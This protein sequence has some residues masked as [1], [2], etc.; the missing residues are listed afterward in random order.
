MSKQNVPALRLEGFSGE[1]EDCTL[2]EHSHV[3]TG[4]SDVQDADPDGLYPFFVRSQHVERSNKYLFDGEAI[5]IPGEGRLGE[6]FHYYIGKFDFHQRVYRISDFED[7]D[8]KYV[9]WAMQHSFKDHAMQNTVKATVDSLRQPTITGF[10]FQ[11]P[12]TLEEQ[13]AIGAIFTNLD[14]AINQHMLKHKALQQSKTALMQRM[15]PQEGQTVPELRLEGFSGEWGSAPLQQL[16]S[17]FTDGDWIESKDQSTEGIRLLQTGN[18]GIGT[19]VQKSATQKWI[20]EETFK[21][22]RCQEV[23]PGDILISRLPDPAGRACIVPMMPYRLITAV[24]CTIVRLSEEN[25]ADYLVAYLG[26]PSY[27]EHID[28]LL[29][30]GTRQRVSRSQLAAIEVPVP[31]TLEEQQAIGAVFT[32]LDQLIAAEAQ[33]IA[34]LK[35]AKTALLQ[36]MFI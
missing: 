24:D 10:I 31:P 13:Q 2:G 14:A 7:I 35:Q 3:T 4:S 15:F 12:P 5:L 21:R 25:D 33:Y 28:T 34:S 17:L 6:I 18:V 19:F 26:N 8:G 30:G 27:F 1:W 23:L 36:R 20:S 16:A 22:L 9:Y 29:A 11:K 32:N